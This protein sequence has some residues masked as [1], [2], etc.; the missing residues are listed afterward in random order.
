[1]NVNN[2]NMINYEN[3][4]TDVANKIKILEFTAEFK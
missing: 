3:V 1:M 4:I 2:W